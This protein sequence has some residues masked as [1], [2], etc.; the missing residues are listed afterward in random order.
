MIPEDIKKS[1][2]YSKMDYTPLFAAGCANATLIRRI[3]IE[4]KIRRGK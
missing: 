4:N 1:R 3:E 2:K